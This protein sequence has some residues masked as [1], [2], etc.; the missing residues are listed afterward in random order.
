[1]EPFVVIGIIVAVI[2]LISKFFNFST[3]NRFNSIKSDISNNNIPI[4]NNLEIIDSKNRIKELKDLNI[5]KINSLNTCSIFSGNLYFDKYFIEDSVYNRGFNRF[6]ENILETKISDL[7]VINPFENPGEIAFAHFF[8]GKE[9]NN[10]RIVKADVPAFAIYYFISESHKGVI[11]WNL[12]MYMEFSNGLRLDSSA[13]DKARE[14][15]NIASLLRDTF[16][17]S[18]QSEIELMKKSIEEK[19]IALPAEREVI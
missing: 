17:N 15:D 10:G 19:S 14:T 3:K 13:G 8:L 1:M 4:N 18:F 16:V 9:L 6:V 11:N 5:I 2:F 7:L 12:K